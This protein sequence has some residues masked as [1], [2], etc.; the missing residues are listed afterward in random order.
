MSKK[1]TFNRLNQLFSDL[2]SPEEYPEEAASYPCDSWTWEAN[3]QGT[4][5]SCGPEASTALGYAPLEWVGQSLYQFAISPH[6]LQPLTRVLQQALFPAELDLE[7]KNADG[8]MVLVRT[9]IFQRSDGE[10][11]PVG[12]RGFNQIVA[13]I[14]AALPEPQPVLPPGNGHQP[15]VEKGKAQPEDGPAEK[16][17]PTKQTLKKRVRQT[18]LTRLIP[19]QINSEGNS[20]L[21]VPIEV[22]GQSQGVI[23]IL[24]VNSARRWTEDD[25]L[26]AQEVA[27]QLA[28][29]LE[30]AQLY[31][32]VQQ[33]LAEKARAEQETL[34]RNRELSLLNQVGQ[35][36]SKLT[37]LQ[38]LI[39]LVQKS[40]GEIVDNQNLAIA[41][42]RPLTQTVTFPVHTVHGI[43]VPQPDRALSQGIID[44]LLVSKKPL[45]IVSE[46]KATL[47]QLGI[48]LPD[49]VP[50]SV[51]GI[52]LLAGERAIGAI[53]VLDELKEGAYTQIEQDL[54]STIAAQATTA[55]ENAN[56]FQEITNALQTLESRERYQANVAR[57]VATLT[58][59][60]TL[61]LP[62][63][64]N[65]LAVASRAG[66]IY[67]ASLATDEKG[68]YWQPSSKWQGPDLSS[69][70]IRDFQRMPVAY[71]PHWATAL[72]EQGW[73]SANISD[74]PAPEREY[75][76]FHGISS[77]LLLAVPGKGPTPNFLA[78]EQ[79]GDSRKWHSEE[80]STLRVSADA[81]SNTIIREDLLEQ[82]QVSLDETENLYNASHRLALAVDLKEMVSAVT[83]DMHNP[84][85]NRGILVLFEQDAYHK[86]EQWIVAESHYSGMGTRPPANKTE[87]S[88]TVYEKLFSTQTPSFIDD[89]HDGALESPLRAELVAQNV[90]S[91]AVL[92]LWANK[93]QL[94][95]LLLETD[96]KH[97]FTGREI[98]SYPPLA[99][100]M[101]TAI[102]NQK[103]FQ[104]TQAALAETGLLYEVSSGIARAVNPNEL[105]QLVAAHMLPKLADRVIL[106]LN[107]Q[108]IEG[109]VS[110]FEIVG[111]FDRTNETNL[112]GMKVPASNLPVLQFITELTS[113]PNVNTSSLDPISKQT[114]LEKLAIQA[115]CVLPLR[116]AGKVIGFLGIAAR[117]PAGFIQDEIRVLQVASGGIAVALE[118]YRLLNEAQ[119]RALELQTAAEIARDTTGTLAI[120]QLL[121]RIVNLLKE[122]FN[123]YHVSIFLVDGPGNFA[124]VQEASGEAGRELKKRGHKIAIGSRTII[125]ATTST[126]TTQVIND[127]SRSTLYFENSLLPDTRSEIG[128]PLKAGDKVIGA[129]DI[130]ANR[131]N[132]FSPDDITVLQILADQI[133]VAI[134]NAKAYELSQQAY[135]DMKEV[136]RVK[137]QFLANM[138][139][140]LRTPLNSIIGFSRVI[141]KG[142]DGPIN[143]TQKQDL[144][145]IYS[146]GQ[147]LLTL[148]NNIL[149][150]SKIEAGKM[151]LQFSEVNISD[152]VNSVMST[153]VGL[154]KDK[155]I[156]LHQQIP[157][158]L[159]LVHA[160][161]TRVR[162]IMLNL[163]AN[164]A[165]FTEEG[166]ITV[167][168]GL[169][170]SPKGKKEIMVTITDTGAGIAL[171]DQDK[172][173]QPFSQVDDLPT[174]KTGGTGLGLSICRS[175]VEMHGGR[176]G[177]LHS[178]IGKGSTFFFTLPI[179]SMD[180]VQEEIAPQTINTVLA[181][182]DDPQVISLYQ[183]YLQPQ[184]YEVVALTNPREALARAKE[185]KPYAITLDIMMPEIDG[186]TV[187]QQ[188]KNDPETREIPIVICS[189]LE[190]EEKGFNLGA[191]DYLVK[192]FLQEDLIQT[193]QRINHDGTIH[194]ILVIDDAPED[195]RLVQKILEEIGEIPGDP[196]R[197]RPKRLGRHS[198][199]S[200][201]RG[202]PGSIHA[203]IWM[204]LRYWRIYDRAPR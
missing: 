146:S 105:T 14:P 102:E 8:N 47:A 3:A 28:L 22:S 55:F 56:L 75:L 179:Q 33:E 133:A 77:I 100:Q 198:R 85:I 129:L 41:L 1:P 122:R 124:E 175:M 128:L 82:L 127:V 200:S 21:A 52:P 155:P 180:P 168:A 197:R 97:P 61:A 140:E 42:Y 103:L 183:R 119:R 93:R 156:K 96:Q 63:V 58:Q 27:H 66:R 138:S 15:P 204:D 193:V 39:F 48:A 51:L 164:A 116:S 98:R 177:L 13:H 54:L 50:A 6:S 141:M 144:S 121:T 203:R 137:S 117:Q 92:P 152:L 23:E 178:E 60:G 69:G 65:I 151:E 147:H 194:Q 78:F 88:R 74:A 5:I 18:G 139:H 94:G 101:A 191:A 19:A 44:F 34:K 16:P 130:H 62:E 84:D 142:I 182:D 72:R 189:I 163:V 36:L 81:L 110:D 70:S 79:Y 181:I 4:F 154:V 109:P 113:I 12:W 17:T 32:T 131:V 188:L 29:A 134:E 40:I 150:L 201:R 157:A 145:A 132:A 126:A 167:E 9:S 199:K 86:I 135:E 89:I 172:L 83:I 68:Q 174:R 10:G 120:N 112:L 187:L 165:K 37:S 162:Q 186:W 153:A 30:N 161:Q 111:S 80:I 53:L 195:L 2:D 59:Y 202:D 38:E 25:R 184:G 158:D 171:Q 173:F 45:L 118:R 11:N 64:L 149:D 71:F 114:L 24:D 35:Q 90:H 49:P 190:D 76:T 87:Y 20:S 185:L 57:A 73:V 159:P 136:D 107:N 99:D 46:V 7:Y 160:D 143:E 196:G 125:G 43:S 169:V 104:Q 170:F 108:A 115:F 106:F 148:I 176:I 67:Y 95:V 192:P 123:F 31:A 91:L 166:S 26:L